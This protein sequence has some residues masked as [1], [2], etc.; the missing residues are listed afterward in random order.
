[1]KKKTLNTFFSKSDIQVK[2][3]KLNYEF[4][5]GKK[6]KRMK[7]SGI[8]TV[9][10]NTD[11]SG[12]DDESTPPE[13]LEKAKEVVNN[14][15]PQ[16]SRPK[17]EAAYVKFMQWRSERKIKSFSE[18]TFLAYFNELA[19]N[20]KPSSLWATYSMLRSM[21][22]IKH[23]I[24]IFYHSNLIAF[25]KQKNKGYTSKKAQVL[26][27]EQI[28]QFLQEAPDNKFLAVKVNRFTKNSKIIYK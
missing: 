6:M 7:M 27:P 23:N 11:A 28:N 9:L 24:N 13:V 26:N 19:T 15:L 22:D 2:S 20:H 18:S 4:I 16:K 17:Y 3:D 10:V 21:I 14:L 5:K 12:T 25:L 8:P 1:L